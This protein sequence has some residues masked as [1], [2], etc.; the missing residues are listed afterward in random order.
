MLERLDHVLRMDDSRQTKTAVLGWYSGLEDIGKTKVRKGKTI[1]FWKRL[2]KEA[3]VSWIEAG[4][5]DQNRDK[6]KNM[7][8]ERMQ[9]LAEWEERKG[10][11]SGGEGGSFEMQDGELR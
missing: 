6:W 11:I 5:L 4:G 2:L 9:H 7:V 8:M 3:R 10:N 1:L